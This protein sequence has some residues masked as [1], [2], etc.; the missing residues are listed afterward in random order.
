MFNQKMK[1]VSII[2]LICVFLICVE[3]RGGVRFRGGFGGGRGRGFGGARAASAGRSSGG[4]WFSGWFGGSG[5][6]SVAPVSTS[7]GNKVG[8]GSS[9]YNSNSLGSGGAGTV[10]KISYGNKVNLASDSSIK[11]GIGAKTDGTGKALNGNT[12][13]NGGNNGGGTNGVFVGTY[14]ATHHSN[15]GY[16]GSRHSHQNSTKPTDKPFI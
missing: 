13:R 7:Y 10:G 16:G 11:S 14:I 3:G 2:F 9:S 12:V 6:K 4:G 1:T 8:I 5:R 15:S